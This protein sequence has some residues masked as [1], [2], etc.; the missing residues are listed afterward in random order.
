METTF[1]LVLWVAVAGGPVREYV[2]DEGLSAADCAAV[3]DV[4]S[5]APGGV[6]V[7]RRRGSYAVAC[8]PET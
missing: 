3:L 6:M 4:W 1:A 7:S 2:I 8:V 5:P